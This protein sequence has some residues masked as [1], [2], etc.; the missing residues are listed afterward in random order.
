[1][2]RERFRVRALHFH[3]QQRAHASAVSSK[4]RALRVGACVSMIPPGSQGFGA[5]LRGLP[6]LACSPVGPRP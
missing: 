4:S 5:S 1:M 3:S 2:Q 6:C